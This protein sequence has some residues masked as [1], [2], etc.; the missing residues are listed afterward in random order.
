M[1]LDKVV[2]VI[3][4]GRRSGEI[5]PLTEWLQPRVGYLTEGRLDRG[6]LLRLRFICVV[7]LRLCDDM[8]RLRLDPIRIGPFVTRAHSQERI[9]PYGFSKKQR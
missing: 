3:S 2:I 6:S 5:Y 8:G 9:E 4:D 1:K 7:A